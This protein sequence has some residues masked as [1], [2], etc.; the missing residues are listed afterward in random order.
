[1]LEALLR[2]AWETGRKTWPQVDLAPDV[3]ERY[4]AGKLPERSE[5]SP[6]APLLEQLAIADL[7][8]AC[9]CV[10]NVPEAAETLERY[11]LARLP[12]LL[13]YLKLPETVLDDVCQSVRIDLL[14][15]TPGAKPQ[16][17]AYT[18][19]GALLSWIRVIAVRKALKDGG[20]PQERP[21]EQALAA[22]EAMPAPGDGAEL[23]LIKHRYR[24]EFRQAVSE[25]FAAL[26]P[27]QRHLLRL[28]YIEQLPTTQLG[29]VFG[30]N[31]STISRWLK[32]AR[33]TVYEETK[34]RLR[35]RLGLSSQEFESLMVAINSQLDLSLSRLLQ[36][37]A[38]SP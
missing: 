23:D 24:R 13:A 11:F 34:H 4:L 16:L 19:R 21:E 14:V 3:F 7:Y 38:G 25:A 35:E 15:G 8:L 28:H 12:S 22:I 18:G 33:A 29:P 32:D 27:E 6:L 30:V 2:D 10:H 20:A 17:T 36:E 1:M 26:S 31:Q 37:E 5:G 9:A